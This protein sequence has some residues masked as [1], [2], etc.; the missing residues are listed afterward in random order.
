MIVPGPLVPYSGIGNESNKPNALMSSKDIDVQ[1]YMNYELLESAIQNMIGTLN[2]VD[3]KEQLMSLVEELDSRQIMKK[4]LESFSQQKKRDPIE[5]NTNSLIWN[6]LI[7]GYAWSVDFKLQ[8]VFPYWRTL[9]DGRAAQDNHTFIFVLKASALLFVISKGEYIHA[10]IVKL[11]LDTYVSN[12]LIH[13]YASC[14]RLGLAWRVFDRMSESSLVSW[15]VIIDEYAQS[16]EPVIELQFLIE[17]QN[18]FQFENPYRISA[19]MAN[20]WATWY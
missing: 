5:E 15:N 8:S 2:L 13:V 12:I 1:V 16:R 10:H 19:D 20:I 17:A 6:I 9:D 3:D 11:R 18:L 7:R 14:G 4:N